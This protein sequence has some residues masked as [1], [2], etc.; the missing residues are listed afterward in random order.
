MLLW[1]YIVVFR[2]SGSTTI[3]K[4]ITDPL[5]SKKTD[6]GEHFQFAVGKWI[7]YRAVFVDP[8]IEGFVNSNGTWAK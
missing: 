3:G 7:G 4:E 6:P 8:Q 5:Y 2:S 1:G